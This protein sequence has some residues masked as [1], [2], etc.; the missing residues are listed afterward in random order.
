MLILSGVGV[1]CERRV[2][3]VLM[4][5]LPA[6]MHMASCCCLQ[7]TEPFNAL[8]RQVMKVQQ[9]L[10]ME[11]AKQAHDLQHELAYGEHTDAERRDAHC[12]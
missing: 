11:L 7:R 2:T 6:T 8:S 5:M 12:Y 3:R 4:V 1:S 9:M 10:K